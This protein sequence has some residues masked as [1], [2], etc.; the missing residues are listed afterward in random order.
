MSINFKIKMKVVKIVRSAFM[1]VLL[2]W[3][4]ACHTQQKPFVKRV[5]KAVILSDVIGKDVQ[6]IDVRTPLEYQQGHIDDAV[7][8]NVNDEKFVRQ[9]E[10][11]NKDKPVYL[12]CKMGGRSNR[13]AELLKSKGFTQIY[14]YSGGYLDWITNE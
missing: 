1:C 12:Y 6:L 7:N 2:L 9:I 8:M 11:L 3:T 14:D 5:D 4:F 10:T 13:A